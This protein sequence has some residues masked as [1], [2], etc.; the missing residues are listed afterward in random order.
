MKAARQMSSCALY[1]ASRA[2]IRVVEE[3]LSHAVLTQ[4][5]D[6]KP[7]MV[8]PNNSFRIA[9]LIGRILPFKFFSVPRDGT[10]TDNIPRRLLTTLPNSGSLLLYLSKRRYSGFRVHVP[11]VLQ[12]RSERHL[13]VRSSEFSSPRLRAESAVYNSSRYLP[14][15]TTAHS[16]QLRFCDH[17]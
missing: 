4:T 15:R 10:G 7:I 16:G 12:S 17:A 5:Q 6:S 11:R 2:P 14:R 3:G 13:C 1:R 8:K 9:K